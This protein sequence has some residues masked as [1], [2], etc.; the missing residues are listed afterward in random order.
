MN[1]NNDYSIV[2]SGKWPADPASQFSYS[3]ADM[4]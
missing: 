1:L 3:F 4:K 2:W